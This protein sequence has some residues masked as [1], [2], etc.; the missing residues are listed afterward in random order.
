MESLLTTIV[1]LDRVVKDR[2]FEES[3]L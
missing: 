2:G 3:A 1:E